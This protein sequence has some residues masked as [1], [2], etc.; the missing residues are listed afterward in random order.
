MFLSIV[1]LLALVGPQSP[2]GWNGGAAAGGR[3]VSITLCHGQLLGNH[4]GMSW[5]T[6]AG[7]SSLTELVRNCAIEKVTEQDS[8]RD[9]SPP[10]TPLQ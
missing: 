1:T 6:M 7:D 10:P 9:I 2:I 3:L 5:V 8:R 4:C